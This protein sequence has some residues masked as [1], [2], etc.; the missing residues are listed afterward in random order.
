MGAR[1]GGLSGGPGL[2]LSLAA[3]SAVLLDLAFPL[4]GPLP[5]LRAIVSMVALL[6]LLYSLAEASAAKRPRAL[7]EAALLGYVT[8][9]L[10]YGLNCY[11]IYATMHIYGG[12]SPAVS[13]GIVVLYSLILGL[14]FA[15]FAWMVA[16]VRRATG[17]VLYAALAVPFFWVGVEYLAAHLTCVPWDQLGYAEVDN[18]LLGRLATVTGVY[19]LSWVLAAV[20]ALW[21]GCFFARSKRR[22]VRFLAGSIVAT[23]VIQAGSLVPFEPEAAGREAVL[24]QPN[25][26]VGAN[27]ADDNDW[28]DTA[29]D[30]SWT[31]HTNQYLALSEDVCTPYLLGMP[32]PAPVLVPRACFPGAQRPALVAWPESPSP[33]RTWD[34][35]FLV[36]LS[37]LAEKTGATSIVGAPL[38]GTHNELYNAAVVTAPN[39]ASLGSYSKIHLVPWGEYVPFQQFFAFAGTLT[40]NVGRFT[41]GHVRSVFTLPDGH[42]MSIFICYEAVFAD[43]IRLFAKAG[44]QVFVNIS[45]DGWYGDTSAPWQHLNMARM[46][47]IENHR[48]IVRDTNSGV[49][50][51]IDPVGRVTESMPRHQLGALV[52]DYGYRSDLTFYTRY[53]DVFAWLCEILSV[54]ALVFAGRE[55][56]HTRQVTA[57]N[58]HAE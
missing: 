30:P 47:A 22:Q 9:V 32:E 34:P 53:G 46:R 49:T 36:L 5:P 4:A 2:R 42:R 37:Q 56:Q 58:E 23:C 20:N 25:L 24:V 12:L 7:R 51:A 39:G 35:K 57:R 8:G 10:W 55:L 18:L 44:A 28:V 52:A 29:A 33:F 19:G 16:F 17:R 1:F 15:L 6:P 27:M 48:W 45:D 13:V 11:W 43:E 14:Y 26:K 40:Q 21:L 41:H 54:A 3:V 50:A 38:L 31:R